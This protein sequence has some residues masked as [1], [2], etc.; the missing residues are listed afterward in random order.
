MARPAR[1]SIPTSPG[2]GPALETITRTNGTEVPI[3][4]NLNVG[5]WGYRAGEEGQVVVPEDGR[6]L[7]ISCMAGI[8]GA[9]VT[10]GGG[11]AIPIPA[12]LG[13]SASIDADLFNSTIDFDGT[14][15]YF[16]Q[17]VLEGQA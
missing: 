8:A 14:V 9:T 5:V 3:V 10:I 2:H 1:T 15:T 11:D 13:F 16:I 12:G 17:Y 6:L 4:S 7:S